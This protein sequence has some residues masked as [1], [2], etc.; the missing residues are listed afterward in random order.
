MSYKLHNY[1]ADYLREEMDRLEESNIEKMATLANLH[2][3]FFADLDDYLENALEA[4]EGG[5]AYE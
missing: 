3:V 2:D 1:L 4:Y 5:A